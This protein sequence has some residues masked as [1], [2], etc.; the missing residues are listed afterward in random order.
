MLSIHRAKLNKIFSDEEI[1]E[2]ISEYMAEHEGDTA[3][4]EERW[5]TQML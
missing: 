5:R 2:K 1:V 3:Q 4:D